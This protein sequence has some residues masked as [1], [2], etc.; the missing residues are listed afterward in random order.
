MYNLQEPRFVSQLRSMSHIYN[1][2]SHVGERNLVQE[3]G[4]VYKKP[5]KVGDA[6]EADAPASS[7]SLLM[8]DGGKRTSSGPFLGH[9]RR[10]HLGVQE[11]P[12]AH[13]VG[14]AASRA[15]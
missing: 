3:V 15:Q 1:G 10:R 9:F 6:V 11:H 13:G 4:R 2:A 12:L 14:S 7:S 8:M 5:E